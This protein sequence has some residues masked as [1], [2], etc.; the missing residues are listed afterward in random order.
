MRQLPGS[1]VRAGWDCETIAAV[2]SKKNDELLSER[3]AVSKYLRLHSY[4]LLEYSPLTDEKAH[5]LS[6]TTC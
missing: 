3:K 6:S 2:A 5:I 1:R 4:H